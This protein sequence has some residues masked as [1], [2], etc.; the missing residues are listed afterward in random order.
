[1]GLTHFDEIAYN[2]YNWIVVPTAVN[3]MLDASQKARASGLPSVI[4]Y[5][6]TAGNPETQT[7]A[8]AL[9]LFQDALSFTESLYDVKDRNALLEIIAKNSCSEA[10]MLYLEFSYRQ[11]GKTDE[12]F[13]IS[14]SRS[15]ASQDDI[16]RDF[17]NIWKVSDSGSILSQEVRAI[18]QK[19]IKEPNHTTIV[20]GYVIRWYIPKAEVD[21]LANSGRKLVMGADSSE[22]IGKDFTTFTIVDVSD[23]SVVA[24]FRCNE[25]NTIKIAQF[26]VNML[27]KYPNL[28]FIPERQNTGIAI[29][30]MAVE[31]CQQKGINP[32]TRIYNNVVQEP[33]KYPNGTI[34]NYNEIP[35]NIRGSFGYRTSG[36]GGQAR[37]L[38]YSL[39]MQ[40][41]LDL[42]AKSVYDRTLVNEFS[43]LATKNGRI[44]H[45][46]GKHD[47]QV[48]SYLLACYL[49][50]FG[51]NLN[52]YGINH[53]E[54]LDSVVA[55]GQKIAPQVKQEQIYIRRRIKEIEN[56]L[57][58]PSIPKVVKMSY[59]RELNNLR[60]LLQEKLIEVAPLALTQVD[61]DQKTIQRY[62]S[63]EKLLNNFANRFL[64]RW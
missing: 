20:D 58:L 2:N 12:W 7:G 42:N 10:P 9:K 30:E 3:A 28:T 50:F 56:N 36:S 45:Q 5:T 21:I 11:L 37:S 4:I 59:E 25:S 16:D 23:V 33:D 35:G 19:S 24:T 49:I 14:A 57:T 1:M 34:Y 54:V 15:K 40:K 39:V 29:T 46:N 43:A 62:G 32:F 55:G 27:F 48:I 52:V 8:Y 61:H 44:D 18:L 13:R 22:N 41:A 60:P 38:L 17:L 26:I 6:T 64:Q 53:D 31:A 51:K 47:D 63:T